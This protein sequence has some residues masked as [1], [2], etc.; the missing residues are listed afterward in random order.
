LRRE[1]GRLRLKKAT[2]DGDGVGLLGKTPGCDPVEAQNELGGLADLRT[3]VT[4][5]RRSEAGL[6]ASG[7]KS[8]S[9][10]PTLVQVQGG[11]AITFDIEFGETGP[12]LSLKS[13]KLSP[14]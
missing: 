9:D 14:Y 5:R 1:S 10:S 8:R 12:L 7:N 6:T 13:S 2:G 3:E 4:G 11:R